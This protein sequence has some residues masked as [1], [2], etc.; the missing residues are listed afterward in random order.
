M[1]LKPIL[2][3]LLFSSMSVW[4]TTP[5]DL[6]KELEAMEIKPKKPDVTYTIRSVE[7][8]EGLKK[9]NDFVLFIENG[10]KNREVVTAVSGFSTALL[11]HRYCSARQTAY[12]LQD[13][14]GK[15]LPLSFPLRVALEVFS[16]ALVS[17]GVYYLF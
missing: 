12:Y 7:S 2:T 3:F 1:K 17:L 11:V 8:L 5:E 6:L 15:L 4:A 16:P 14:N 13:T 9:I 10:I